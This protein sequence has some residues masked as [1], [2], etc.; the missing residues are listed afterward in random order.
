M[1]VPAGREEGQKARYDEVAPSLENL[2]LVLKEI[3]QYRK[4][5]AYYTEKDSVRDRKSTRLNSSH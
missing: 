4:R 3:S 1:Q 5:V 2:D